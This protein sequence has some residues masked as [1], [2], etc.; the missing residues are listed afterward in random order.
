MNVR[1]GPGVVFEAAGTAGSGLTE[2]RRASLAGDPDAGELAVG[3]V[4]E[5]KSAVPLPLS[6]SPEP[7]DFCDSRRL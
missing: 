2:L 7:D 6:L 4:T 1:E 3:S 5:T